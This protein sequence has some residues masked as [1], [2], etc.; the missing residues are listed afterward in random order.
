MRA[1]KFAFVAMLLICAQV[2]PAQVVASAET[3]D[4]GLPTLQERS[5]IALETVSQN[6]TGY[7]TSYPPQLSRT[8]LLKAALPSPAVSEE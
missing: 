6:I 4:S 5:L 2:L 1:S 3:A 8:A 7:P